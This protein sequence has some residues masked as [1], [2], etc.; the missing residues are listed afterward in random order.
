MK[1]VYTTVALRTENVTADDL[2]MYHAIAEIAE[3]M[4][5]AIE[6]EGPIS[7]SLLYRRVLHSYGLTRIGSRLDQVFASAAGMLRNQITK[8]NTSQF[9]WPTNL[10]PKDCNYFRIQASDNDRRV[11]EDLPVQEIVAAVIYILKIQFSMSQDD[12]VREISKVFGY[13]RLGPNVVG[14]IQ[15]GIDYALK[16]RTISVENGMVVLFE[17]K[18]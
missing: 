9:Y 2:C 3:K 12:L 5:Q 1:K 11:A 16:N 18:T 17:N 14:A 6:V 10:S 7:K 13:S 15:A 8:Q 4:K